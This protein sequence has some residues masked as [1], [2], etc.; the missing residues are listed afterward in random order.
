MLWYFYSNAYSIARVVLPALMV[1]G[2][3]CQECPPGM[4]KTSFVRRQFIFRISKHLKT[5][6]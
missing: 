4:S 3:L 2:G 6:L 1:T 5:G